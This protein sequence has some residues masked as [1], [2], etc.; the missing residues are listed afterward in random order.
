MGNFHISDKR[1]SGFCFVMYYPFLCSSGLACCRLLLSLL[2]RVSS[3]VLSKNCLSLFSGVSFILFMFSSL[4]IDCYVFY[5]IFVVYCIFSWRFVCFIYF[6]CLII[7]LFTFHFCYLFKLSSIFIIYMLFSY[8]T[9]WFKVIYIIV[10]WNDYYLFI[11][12]FYLFSS[13]SY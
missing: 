3:Y 6:S 10:H 2:S 4:Q 12:L 5:L 1:C 9:Y 11:I 8:R 7:I 13:S